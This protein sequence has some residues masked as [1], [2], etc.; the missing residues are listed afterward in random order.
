VGTL[1][2]FVRDD[3]AELYLVS[4]NHVIGGSS[5]KSAVAKFI[6]TSVVQ[7]GTLDLTEIE[8]SLM[9]SEPTLE[10][11]L[12]IAE[13]SG[14]VPLQFRT[15]NAIPINKVDAALAKLVPP[16]RTRDELNRST[17]LGGIRGT[18][19][20]QVDPNAPNRVTGDSR[21]YKAGRTTGATEGIVTSIGAVV[22]IEYSKG[23][24]AFFNGQI[25]IEPTRD[26][27]RPFSKP[28]DSGSGVLNARHELV[29]QLFAGSTFQTLVNPIELVL[30]E[31]AVALGKAK[32]DVV[33]I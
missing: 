31:L 16:G 6:G 14:I 29:G 22:T 18:A 7:P 19:A 32:L 15:P 3:A 25:V 21:V 12:K 8:L 26:N 1:G 23:N 20:F 10:K 2:F 30:A 13:V 9:P 4:N 27:T 28:G 11:Q 33:T 5:D 24:S 17:F